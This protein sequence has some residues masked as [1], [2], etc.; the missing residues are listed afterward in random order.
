MKTQRTF[1]AVFDPL[2]QMNH[3][4]IHTFTTAKILSLVR[5]S[6]KLDNAIQQVRTNMMPDFSAKKKAKSWMSQS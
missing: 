5:A 2:D 1:E 4:L 6:P 3:D